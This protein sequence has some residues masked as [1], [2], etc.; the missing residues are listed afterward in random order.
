MC[1]A[2]TRPKPLI[3]EQNATSL[4]LSSSGVRTATKLQNVALPASPPM[5]INEPV[6]P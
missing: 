4:A 6:L 1:V 5:P 3:L 2:S